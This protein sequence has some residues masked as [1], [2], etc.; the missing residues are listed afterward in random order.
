MNEQNILIY[1]RHPVADAI[2]SGK[3]FEK[4]MMQQGLRG[5]AEIEI[6]KLA[7]EF[8]IPLSIVP[9]EK[10]SK[11]AFRLFQKQKAKYP[12]VVDIQ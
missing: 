12:Q 10:M 7:K 11:V 3:A 9:R 8:N 6:R 2:R 5:E 1:G 4:V